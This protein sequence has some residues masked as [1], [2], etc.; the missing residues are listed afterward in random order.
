MG[1]G[2]LYVNNAHLSHGHFWMPEE[3]YLPIF[4]EDKEFVGSV[5]SDA[6]QEWEMHDKYWKSH[7]RDFVL[8]AQKLSWERMRGF[9]IGPEAV[10][11]QCLGG[12]ETARNNAL[13]I[14]GV[15]FKGKKIIMLK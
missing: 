7:V 8:I 5:L 4:F 14:F 9:S 2:L 10:S 1:F 11:Q 6:V 12:E 3:M 13:Y 15:N